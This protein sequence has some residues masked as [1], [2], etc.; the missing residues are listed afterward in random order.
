MFS[1]NTFLRYVIQYGYKDVVIGLIAKT[2]HVIALITTII[3]TGIAFI[4]P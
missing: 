2:I 4:Y 3:S 1:D